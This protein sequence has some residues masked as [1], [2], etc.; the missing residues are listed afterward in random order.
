MMWDLTDDYMGM[1][2]TYKIKESLLDIELHQ[3]KTGDRLI[4]H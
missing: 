2:Y 1:G 3:A 4:E